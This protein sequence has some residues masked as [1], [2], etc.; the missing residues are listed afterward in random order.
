MSVSYS[1]RRSIL[2]SVVKH[3]VAAHS[4][5]FVGFL[6]PQQL[7]KVGKVAAVQHNAESSD[8]KPFQAHSVVRDVQ[9]LVL[10]SF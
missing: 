10:E 6:I 3:E 8:R 4:E 9:S 5:Q 2:V 1:A 7:E